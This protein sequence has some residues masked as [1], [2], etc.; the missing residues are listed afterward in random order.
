M[1]YIF[2]VTAL[3]L[4]ASCTDSSEGGP[5]AGPAS[6]GPEKIKL[7]SKGSAY[8]K[9]DYLIPGHTVILDFYADW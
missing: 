1:R 2:V 3:S 4:L 5:K 6:M 7:I 9:K 8:D